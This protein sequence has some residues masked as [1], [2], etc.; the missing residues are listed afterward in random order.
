[1]LGGV[2]AKSLVTGNVTQPAS[3][4]EGK[5]VGSVLLWTGQ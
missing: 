5:G 3:Q 1:M 4:I 2:F